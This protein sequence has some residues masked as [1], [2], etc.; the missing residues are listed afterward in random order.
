[1]AQLKGTGAWHA[2]LRAWAARVVRLKRA[3]YAAH[4]TSQAQF[5]AVDSVRIRSAAAA[6]PSQPKK[7]AVI[8]HALDRQIRDSYNGYVVFA[9]ASS[10]ARAVATNGALFEGR[11]LR[12]DR[13]A[14]AAAASKRPRS[15]PRPPPRPPPRSHCGSECP[16]SQ[17]LVH[18]SPLPTPPRR[19]T[20]CAQ[21]CP[22]GPRGPTAPL[23]CAQRGVQ[24]SGG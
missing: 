8:T 20:P 16:G 7:A 17:R 12:I 10:V 3:P 23:G 11:H 13:L 22:G 1:M 4:L 19:P 6:D 2:G 18:P 24:R 21:G 5:G 9:E 14:G 15:P